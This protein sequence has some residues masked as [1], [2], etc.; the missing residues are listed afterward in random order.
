MFINRTRELSFLAKRYDSGKPELIIVYGRRRVGK[1]F[2]LK[3]FLEKRRGAYLMV[4]RLGRHAL[5][6]FSK[7]LEEQLNI[8]RPNLQDYR[9]LYRFL[10]DLSRDERFVLVIDEFQRLAESDE[11]FLMELQEAWD[12]LLRDT[13]AMVV[14]VG[15]SVGVIERVALSSSSPIF[16]RRTGQLKVSPMSFFSS[17]PFM[18]HL[19]PEDMVRCYAVF[20]G[21]PAYLSLIDRKEGLLENI[22]NLILDNR[23]P[24]Y[25]EPYYL[26]A[27]ETREPLRYMA[28]LEAMASG[29]S[30]LGEIASKSGM[31]SSELPRY[32]KVLE[33]DLDIIRREVPL[34]ERKVRGK[35]R[36]FL[37]DNLFKFWFTFVRPNLHLLEM[38]EVDRVQQVVKEELDHYTSAIFEEIALEHFIRSVRT[39]KVGR[40]WRGDVEIDGVAVDERSDTAYFMEAKWTKRPVG[41]E[42]LHSLIR[43]AEEFPWRS[44]RRREIYY[45][46]SRSGFTFSGDEDVRLVDLRGMISKLSGPHA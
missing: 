9:D 42:V 30:V 41:R 34:L 26:L 28:I 7:M 16:G 45:I 39:N 43:K 15:S 6:D 32:I 29:A 31:S 40:W 14:L 38:G 11:S 24:L 27:E 5:E 2:L 17:I 18:D 22:K 19:N 46:Y 35:T 20:G 10:A 4:S 12:D 1:T 13:K 44:G 37:K 3:K 21:V 25:E 33:R 8:F 23:A 36:Y